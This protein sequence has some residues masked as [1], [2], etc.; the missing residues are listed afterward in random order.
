[1]L[2]LIT[3]KPYQSIRPYMNH[4]ERCDR[5]DQFIA[6]D[7]LIRN[8]WSFIPPSGKEFACLLIA[9]VPEALNTDDPRKACPA[10]VMP[11]WLAHITTVIDDYPTKEYWSTVIRRYASLARQWDRLTPENW[12]QINRNM[13]AALLRLLP[14]LTD[15]EKETVE[16]VCFALEFRPEPELKKLQFH[17]AGN[18][19]LR[20]KVRDVLLAAVNPR[21]EECDRILA[22]LHLLLNPYAKGSDIHSDQ[23]TV[24]DTILD[25]IED[26]LTAAGVSV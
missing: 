3:T 18:T 26:G 16:N 22:I 11:A 1:M 12:N 19:D 2:W 20:Y 8:R 5:L 21:N 9:L 24:I 10:E 13:R 7:R 6:E 15:L 23:N 25:T 14:D 17:L 4:A